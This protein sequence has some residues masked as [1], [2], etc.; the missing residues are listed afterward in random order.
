VLIADHE[1]GAENKKV[2]RSDELEQQETGPDESH[3]RGIRNPI[4]TGVEAHRT[5]DCEEE[6]EKQTRYGF[7]RT[8]PRFQELEVKT[9][10]LFLDSQH[11]FATWILT[12]VRLDLFS[13]WTITGVG[14]HVTDTRTATTQHANNQTR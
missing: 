13:H 2:V 10:T 11:G 3:V 14:D 9:S 12:R 4:S 5:E 8:G 1:R 6:E 7:G